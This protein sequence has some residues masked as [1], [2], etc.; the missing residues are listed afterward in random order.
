MMVAPEHI[1]QGS[2]VTYSVTI[3]EPPV[4][5]LMGGLRDGQHLRM[6][7]RVVGAFDLIMGGGDDFAPAFDDGADRDLIDAPGVHGQV[8]GQSHVKGVIPDQLR[9]AEL[10]EGAGEARGGESMAFAFHGSRI[11]RVSPGWQ[12]GRRALRYRVIDS[13][14]SCAW[15]GDALPPLRHG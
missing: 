3:V 13:A 12:A 7:G 9:R 15:I 8:E 11:T 10:L 14:P 5:D 4:A 6:R 2:L 1:G